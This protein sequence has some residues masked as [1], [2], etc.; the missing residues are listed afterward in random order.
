M[1]ARSKPLPCRES[2]LC[3]VRL[4]PHQLEVEVLQRG[5]LARQVLAQLVRDVHRQPPLVEV[6]DHDVTGSRHRLERA[7]EAEDGLKP[8]N[9]V[10]HERH[11]D[12]PG[13]LRGLHA[14]PC[15]PA[16]GD[17]AF[18]GFAGSGARVGG[19]ERLAYLGPARG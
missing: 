1:L 17:A 18:A 6:A 16:G 14:W 3:P 8:G 2:E 12:S 10:E 7:L 9:V 11:R 5:D 13:G 4:G 19:A 15:R